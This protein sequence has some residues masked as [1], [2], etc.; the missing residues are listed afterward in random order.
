[1]TELRTEN[2]WLE[3]LHNL[4]HKAYSRRNL[5]QLDKIIEAISSLIEENANYQR[6]NK[7][8]R[9]RSAKYERKKYFS[10]IAEIQDLQYRIKQR[11]KKRKDS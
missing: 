9:L 8:K 3:S 6:R 11:A 10:F 7:G 4:I 5:V 1:M 2:K